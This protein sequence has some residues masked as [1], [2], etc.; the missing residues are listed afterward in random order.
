MES[1]RGL[2][3]AYGTQELFRLKLEGNSELLAMAIVAAL[4]ESPQLA[5][6]VAR[7]ISQVIARESSCE[8]SA[9]NADAWAAQAVEITC[10]STET[11]FRFFFHLF[12]RLGRVN[13]KIATLQ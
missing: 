4:I 10:S 2:L 9:E 3:E 13:T 6:N 7:F 8:S 12:R 1:E 5:V 11:A